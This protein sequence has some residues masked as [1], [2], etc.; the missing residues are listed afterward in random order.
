MANDD[1]VI[2][3]INTSLNEMCTKN[4]LMSPQAFEVQKLIQPLLKGS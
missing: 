3:S 2:Q 4:R 1:L